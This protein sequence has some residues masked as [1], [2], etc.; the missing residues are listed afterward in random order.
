MYPLKKKK[1]TNLSYPKGASRA[2]QI[3]RPMANSSCRWP[4]LTATRLPSPDQIWLEN[5]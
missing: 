2:G 3:S 5:D 4:G 1:K